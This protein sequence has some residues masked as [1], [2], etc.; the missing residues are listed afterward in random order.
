MTVPIYLDNHATT[1]VD[2]RVAAVVNQYLRESYGNP[3]SVDHMHGDEAADT[4]ASARISAAKL[5]NA[6]DHR[7]IFTSGATESA[8]LAIQGFASA[9]GRPGRRLRIVLSEVEHPAVSATCEHLRNTGAAELVHIPVD[10]RGQIRMERAYDA[11]SPGADLVCVMAANNIVGTIYPI[12]QITSLA[13]ECGAAVF[14]DATQ[15][16]GHIRVDVQ[17]WGVDAIAFSGHKMYGPKGV[18][19]LAVAHG[20]DLL[21]VYHGGGQEHGLR[22]GTINVPGVAGLAEACRLS[23]M[24]LDAAAARIASLRGRL[25]KRLEEFCPDAV[26]LGDHENKLPGNLSVCFPRIPNKAIIAR[27]RHRL[28]VATGA[29]CSSGLEQPSPVLAA[30]G[31]PG[32]LAEGHLRIGVGK[33]NTTKEIDEAALLLWD[34]VTQIGAALRSE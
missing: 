24:E 10:I 4:V 19:A 32:I 28:S 20:F 21:P 3:S 27:I 17:Q 31:V 26:F 5:L 30:M 18:G 1:Q 9:R 6:P 33:F 34:A 2:E 8:N 7:V 16:V 15:A 12:E 11:I 22:P 13:H 23:A 25:Q 14:V 29:A